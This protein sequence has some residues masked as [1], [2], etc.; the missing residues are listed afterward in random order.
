[1]A[2][3]DEAKD[4]TRSKINGKIVNVKLLK[5]DQYSR[6]LGKVVT[7]DC[8]PTETLMPTSSSSDSFALGGKTCKPNNEHLDLSL[9]LA[10][11]GFSTLYRGGGAE[12]DGNK[13]QL[14]KEIQFAQIQRKGVWTNGIEN[15]Q[16]PAD[17]KKAIRESAK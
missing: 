13:S 10:H 8:F 4:Y 12:Y 15:A 9:G 5:K 6:V 1:M 17:Y 3:A 11:N 14:E 2:F 7:D 16:S